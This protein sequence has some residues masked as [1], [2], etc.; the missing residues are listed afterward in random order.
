M[1]KIYS[2]KNGEASL[3][4]DKWIVKFNLSMEQIK[5]IYQQRKKGKESK[6]NAR[7]TFPIFNAHMC[8]SNKWING[9]L[10]CFNKK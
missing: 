7:K 10:L 2:S 9:K 3:R 6:Q 4:S 1:I 5:Q 8:K